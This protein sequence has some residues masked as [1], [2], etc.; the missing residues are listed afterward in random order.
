[1][2]TALAGRARGSRGARTDATGRAAPE[3]SDG[4]RVVTR[5][6]STTRTASNASERRRRIGHAPGHEGVVILRSLHYAHVSTE[7]QVRE[8]VDGHLMRLM[9]QEDRRMQAHRAA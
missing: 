6:A 4:R 5:T 2:P 1:M 3:P 8:D 9:R 7:L